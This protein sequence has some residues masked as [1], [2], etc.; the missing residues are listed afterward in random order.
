MLHASTAW[1]IVG[2]SI[3]PGVKL[4]FREAVTLPAIFQRGI[5]VTVITRLGYPYLP[6]AARNEA[7]IGPYYRNVV[8]GYGDCGSAIVGTY[9]SFVKRDLA[10]PSII[11]AS[12]LYSAFPRTPAATPGYWV[13]SGSGV[14]HSFITSKAKLV[15]IRILLH[16]S[17]NCTGLLL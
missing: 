7:A 10:P 12:E 16:L 17:R 9:L 8:V 13:L 1:S 11:I 4:N 15:A 14:P 6:D 2:V 5:K 3:I